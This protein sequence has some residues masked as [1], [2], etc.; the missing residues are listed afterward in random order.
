MNKQIKQ[1][2]ERSIFYTI[3]LTATF[4]AIMLTFNPMWN[5]AT[6]RF[7]YFHLCHPPEENIIQINKSQ[8]IDLF[9]AIKAWRD[10]KRIMVVQKGYKEKK[11][12]RSLERIVSVVRVINCSILQALIKLNV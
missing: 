2:M 1:H 11:G 8:F 4:R 3:G 7:L 12:M 5:N 10:I 9:S 6:D